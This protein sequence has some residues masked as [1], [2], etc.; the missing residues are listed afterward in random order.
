MGNRYRNGFTI[1]EVMLFLAVSGAL[2]VGVLATSSIAIN[3]QRYRDALNTMQS[4]MQQQFNQTANV[5]NDR[6][7]DS[8]CDDS[9]IVSTTNNNAVAQPRGTSECLVMGR[10]IEFAGDGQ[11]MNFRTV[12]GYRSSEAS[13]DVN[14]DIVALRQYKLFVSDTNAV[15]TSVSW[16][17]KVRLKQTTGTEPFYFVLLRSPVTGSLRTFFSKGSISN[18]EISSDLIDTSNMSE[19]TFCLESGGF[20]VASTLGVVIRANAASSNAIELLG[21]K[22]AC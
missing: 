8:H 7:S 1:I 16:G 12:V 18:N 10:T 17:A 4:S 14:S 13:D 2:A 20:T 19:Q 11:A 3:Q 15:S 5:V 22:Q 21:D 9:G 6:T